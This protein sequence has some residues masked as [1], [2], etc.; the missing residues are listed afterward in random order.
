MIVLPL[1][2]ELY[3]VRLLAC[4]EQ[5][6][7]TATLSEQQ[8]G[9]Q[10]QLHFLPQKLPI[11]VLLLAQLPRN[12]HGKLDRNALLLNYKDKVHAH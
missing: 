5:N 12:Q 1:A 6:A 7:F 10:L 11:K 2:D 4:V 3:G 9:E 8:L